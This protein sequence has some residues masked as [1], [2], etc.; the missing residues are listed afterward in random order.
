MD[1][2]LPADRRDAERVAVAADP[3][4]DTAEEVA[5]ARLVQRA[6]AERIEDGDGARA[7]REDVPH[8]TADARCRALIWLD[9]ARVIMRLHL[10]GQGEAVADIDD[11]RVLARPLQDARPGR[12]E[13]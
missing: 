6:E 9:R 10:Q 12:R 4:D 8:D 1:I 3:R 11:A 7:H 5:I 2:D 13:H